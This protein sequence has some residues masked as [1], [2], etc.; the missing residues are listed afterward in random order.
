[1]KFK[2]QLPKNALITRVLSNRWARISLAAAAAVF[3]IS[4]SV[5]AYYY[6]KY[7]RIIEDKLRN[8]PFANTSMLY[9]APQPVA[10]GDQTKPEELAEYLRRTGYTESNRNPLGWYHVRP[11]AIEIN[12]GPEAFDS[13][14]A[15]IKIQRGVV[16]QI[17]SLRDQSE[18][19]LYNLEP[20]P[21]TNLFDAKREKRRIVRYGDIPKV[22]IDATLSAEDKHFFSHAGFDPIGIMRAIVVDI[23]DRRGTQ[24]ASTL[25]QQLARTL[26]L[27]NERGWKRK[28][29]ESLITLH[30]ERQLTKE[31]IF[32][33]YA[34]AIYL[35][36][37]GS[38]SIHGFAQ[39]ASVYL[40]KDLSQVT[41]AD[42]ALIAGLIQ[43]PIGRNPFRYPDRARGRRN[44][45]LKAMRENGYLTEEQFQDAAAS[46]L[47]VVQGA[48]ESTDAPYFVDLVNDTLQNRFQQLDFQNNSYRVYTSLDM[49]LQRDAVEA[50]RLGIKE[51]DEQW[52]RRNK[53]YGTDEMPL[54][55]VALV[56]LDTETGQV[57]ALV[58]GR[59]YGM[60][61][62]DHAVAKRQ[63]GSSFKP[64]VYTAAFGASLEEEGKVITPA[65]T[66][67]DEPT[68]FMF[69]DKPYE[70]ADFEDKYSGAVTLRQAL[71]H[72]MNIPAVKVAEM[73]GYDKVADTA[74]AVEIGRAHV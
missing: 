57:K 28:I 3:V 62:L 5:F 18:R 16:T 35:G 40:G 55:Q 65:T 23:K 52:K 71:A 58:G 12:P 27:G 38:F 68:T 56:A 36:H 66:V 10:V 26:W 8:G 63:P 72:S 44:V 13:E 21:I 46:P 59:S 24:G 41:A 37:Q 7:A 15:V 60:S 70:P 1:M 19:T 43:S 33:D 54:A 74:R 34:N 6:N 29:P 20:E 22:M 51:T 42:A 67:V 53:K 30:L 17:I 49:N 32:E 31:Q 11:D 2:L 45:I 69:D 39:A 25:T 48:A 9:A 50:V 73:I 47:N 64:F 61:Q 14:G 4:V